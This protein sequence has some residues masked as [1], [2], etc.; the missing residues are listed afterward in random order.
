[1]D[2]VLLNAD[3][4]LAARSGNLVADPLGALG[5]RLRFGSGLCLRGF[6]RM[7]VLHPVLA[8]LSDFAPDF[9]AA[10]GSWPPGDCC[11]AGMEALEFCRVVELIGH[12]GPPRLEIYHTLRGR[13]AAGSDEEVKGWR[14]EMLLD[15]PLRMGPLKHVVFGDQVSRFRFE[16]VVNLFDFI[17]GVLWQL[18]FHGTPLEC[19]L[20]RESHV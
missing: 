16:T 2:E 13:L 6:M 15:V 18:A 4:T 3:G 9:A 20:R 1:M 19:A 14:V 5:A 12:P 8:R 17:E 7:L 10:Y 11:P